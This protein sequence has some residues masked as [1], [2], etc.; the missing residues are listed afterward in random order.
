[1]SHFSGHG[2]DCL[3]L[4]TPLR[5]DFEVSCGL[6]LGDWH[7]ARVRYGAYQFDLEKEWKKYKLHDTVRDG[8]QPVTIAPPL[9]EKKGDVYQFRRAVKDGWLRAFVDGREIVAERIGAD[10]D[11]WLMIYSPSANMSEVKDFK[12]TGK[13]AVPEVVDMLR[14]EDLGL[15]R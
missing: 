1:L 6:R 5:G 12:V 7:D 9:P 15:W 3:F 4:R 13:V 8:G 2:D 11:P 14:G 10:P